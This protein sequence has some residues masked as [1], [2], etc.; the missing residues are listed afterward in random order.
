[1]AAPVR[2]LSQQQGPRTPSFLEGPVEEAAPFLEHL[3]AFPG[4][5]KPFMEVGR[6]LKRQD[7][8][9]D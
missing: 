7:I 5:Q 6:F 4:N 2:G 1:M 3:V 8:Q 9:E